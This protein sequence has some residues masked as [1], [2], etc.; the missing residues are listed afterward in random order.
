MIDHDLNIAGM[1]LKTGV[2]RPSIY[3]LLEADVSPKFETLLQILKAFNMSLIDFIHFYEN[4][5]M[6][7]EFRQMQQRELY[8]K[9]NSEQ[10]TQNH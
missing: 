5:E 3:V 9:E 6:C 8:D 7:L 1:A 2:K 10:S 4:D